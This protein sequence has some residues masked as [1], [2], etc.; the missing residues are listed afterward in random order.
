MSRKVINVSKDDHQRHVEQT[1]ANETRPSA[2]VHLS[3]NLKS[4]KMIDDCEISFFNTKRDLFRESIKPP[5]S[6]P[7][8]GIS[9]LPSSDSR[10]HSSQCSLGVAES[11]PRDPSC[12][13]F[14]FF[15]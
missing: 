5:Y 2:A 13:R 3:E 6:Q 8:D 12:C 4:K 7:S 9:I 14:L 15:K 10:S 1:V 11:Y